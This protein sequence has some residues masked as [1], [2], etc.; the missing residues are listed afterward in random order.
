MQEAIESYQKENSLRITGHQADRSGAVEWL[1][2]SGRKG[3]VI[4]D[5]SITPG[6]V[7][8]SGSSGTIRLSG[9]EDLMRIENRLRAALESRLAKLFDH[10]K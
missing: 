8:I 3:E 5:S 4:V 6:D 1:R 7:M 10:Q 9:R 2:Q